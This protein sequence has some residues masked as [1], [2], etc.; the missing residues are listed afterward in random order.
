MR[1][2]LNALDAAS[3]V[4][5]AFA[6]L[7]VVGIVLLIV[8]EVV[9]RTL[10]NLSLSFAWEYSAYFLGIAI[11]CG[12][13]FTLRTGGHVRVTFLTASKRP[14]VART[15]EY[16]ATIFGVVITFYMAYSLGLFAWRAFAT[17]STS[18]TIDAV[19]LVFPT[20]G[21]AIGAILMALQM[22]SRLIR[23][24]ID[25]PTEDEAA[26]RSYSVE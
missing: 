11:F 21:L 12:A 10:F 24:I 25:E 8:T 22:V 23:L 16:I 14:Y 15:V 20:S 6:V 4:A 2:L 26:M 13:A 17:G 5:G 18:P 1:A 7:L 3:R 9:C 19:P